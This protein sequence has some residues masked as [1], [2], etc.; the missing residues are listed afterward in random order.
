MMLYLALK[1]NDR[2]FTLVEMVVTAII[3]GVLAAVSVPNLLGMYNR[4][5]A[6]ATLEKVEGAIKEAQRLAVRNGRSCTININNSERSISGGCL[7]SSRK[8]GDYIT[9]NSDRNTVSFTAKG[10]SP[11][12]ATI[13]VGSEYTNIDRCL[14]ITTGIGLIRTGDYNSVENTCVPRT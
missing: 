14:V 11:N 9:L 13:R 8:F 10:T 4:Q 6:N 3:L 7:L 2:G 12:A 5:R 1:K